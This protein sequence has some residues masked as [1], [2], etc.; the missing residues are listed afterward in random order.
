[1]LACVHLIYIN[2]CT[3]V[4][5]LSCHRWLRQI[6]EAGISLLKDVPTEDNMV[7]KVHVVTPLPFFFEYLV[8]LRYRM[9]KILLWELG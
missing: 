2:T 6:N 8:S 1:M 4:C 3:Y 7:Q 9:Y 5:Y